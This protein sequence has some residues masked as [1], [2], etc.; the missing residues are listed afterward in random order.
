MT[1]Q[2]V[3][4]SKEEPESGATGPQKEGVEAEWQSDAPRRREL[5]E[6]SLR[7]PNSE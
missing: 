7:Y 5:R 4:M 6:S 3:A 2:D 1:R